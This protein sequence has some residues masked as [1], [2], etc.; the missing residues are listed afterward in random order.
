MPDKNA[1]QLQTL[2]VK[3]AFLEDHVDAINGTLYQQQRKIEALEQ[4]C[5]HL[6][7]KIEGFQ[8]RISGLQVLDEKPPHY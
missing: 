8:E 5:K 6:T 3:I 2:E 1:E 4:R 7:E